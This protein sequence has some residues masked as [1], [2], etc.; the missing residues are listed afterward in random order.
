MIPKQVFI[1]PS[2]IKLLLTLEYFRVSWGGGVTTKKW[3]PVDG[4]LL[5]PASYVPRNRLPM[6]TVLQVGAYFGTHYF[7]VF[8]SCVALFLTSHLGER[9]TDLYIV[10]RV[11][12]LSDAVSR[13]G[14]LV[15]LLK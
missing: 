9:S 6:C 8:H 12:G 4:E 10:C 13:V 2:E 14:S 15:C 1:F 11:V 7:V 5:I 3:S